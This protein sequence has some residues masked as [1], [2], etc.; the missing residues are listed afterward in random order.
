[1][2]PPP[3]VSVVVPTYNRPEYLAETLRSITAQTFANFEAFI[4][5]DGPSE[6]TRAVVESF[7]DARL[8]YLSVPHHGGPGPARNAGIERARGEFV[9]FCDDDDLWH[10][11]KLEA[12]LAALERRSAALCYT[13]CVNI[14]RLSRPGAR[15]RMPPRHYDWSPRLAYLSLPCYYISPSSVMLPMRVFDK[16]GRFDLRPLRGLEDAELFVR[17]AFRMKER[18]VRVARPL[19]HYRVDPLSPGL[20]LLTSSAE[21]ETLLE[22]VQ[23]HVPMRPRTFRR[24]AAVQ[25]IVHARAV[26][27][28]GDDARDA[29]AHLD[30]ADAYSRSVESAVVRM[31]LSRRRDVST[32][33]RDARQVR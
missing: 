16:V 32:A 15:L 8:H 21:I 23:E 31:A 13:G 28:R 30:R 24:Y 7:D 12:Q 5:S 27:F 11:S 4:V 3:R 18:F 29:L 10:P 17:I 22:A 25:W 20:G 9:A 2:A 14:D 19:V 33:G 6:T 26:A 1:M